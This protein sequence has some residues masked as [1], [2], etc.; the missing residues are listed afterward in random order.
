MSP[1][2]SQ[3]APARLPVTALRHTALPRTHAAGLANL[4]PGCGA[5]VLVS[6]SPLVS[7]CTPPP[8]PSSHVVPGSSRTRSP[9]CPRPRP[10]PRP[11][12]L[13]LRPPPAVGVLLLVAPGLRFPVPPPLRWWSWPRQ[14]S[15]AEAGAPMKSAGPQDFFVGLKSSGECNGGLG[16]ARSLA[17]CPLVGHTHANGLLWHAGMAGAAYIGPTT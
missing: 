9:P 10:P 14:D 7:D 4:T 17:V 2:Q 11:A 3:R 5:W 6:K 12:L 8:P 15:V 13:A 1:S 16:L